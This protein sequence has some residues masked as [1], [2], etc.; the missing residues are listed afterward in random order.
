[1]HLAAESILVNWKTNKNI[2]PKAHKGKNYE[3]HRK[4]YHRYM[5]HSKR[6]NLLGQL[7]GSVNEARDS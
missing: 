1:M 4:L 7:R 2:Q 3:R 6:W 5:G